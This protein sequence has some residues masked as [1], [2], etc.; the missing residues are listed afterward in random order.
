MTS[1][2]ALFTNMVHSRGLGS[3][4]LA[5]LLGGGGQNSTLEAPPFFPHP[6]ANQ[7][8]LFCLVSEQK[9]AVSRQHPPMGP[10]GAKP[11]PVRGGPLHPPQEF[12]EFPPTARG[13][14]NVASEQEMGK[15]EASPLRVGG[16]GFL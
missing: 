16:R 8:Q 7:A 9:N 3:R 12:L 1:A 4:M 5:P 10:P 2:K 15:G 6:I 14:L 13:S 11:E